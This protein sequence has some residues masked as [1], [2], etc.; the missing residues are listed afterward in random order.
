[1]EIKLASWLVDLRNE[2]IV[3]PVRD[4][5]RSSSP[6]LFLGHGEA[7]AKIAA[8]WGQAEF[9]EPWQD[10][11]PEDRVLLYGYFIQIRHLRELTV[12]FRYLF[13]KGAPDQRPVVID[14]GCGPFTGALALA[15]ALGNVVPFDYI[16]MDRS[17]TMLKL[18]KQLVS[19]AKSRGEML[20]VSCR[21][22]TELASIPWSNAPSWQPVFVIMSYL[23]ASPT[24][25]VERLVAD[26]N[27]LIG[28]IGLGHVTVLYTNS[29]RPA[30]NRRF[31]AFSAALRDAGFRLDTHDIGKVEIDSG[32][33]M[34]EYELR[35][36]VFSRQRR[37]RLGLGGA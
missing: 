27:E 8:G 6:D 9:D 36:A 15:G 28:R 13:R 20:D 24:L 12:A 34:S 2:K 17:L 37:N 5:P 7:E 30:P 19:S 4:D 35:Y 25:D 32:Y 29:P 16:G 18:G 23:L 11:K 3:R 33:G 14:L 22:A 26:L 1:M 10:L 31:K 21:H